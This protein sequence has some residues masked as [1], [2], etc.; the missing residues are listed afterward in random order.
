MKKKFLVNLYDR[1]SKERIAQL[2]VTAVNM[3][4]A[5]RIAVE[6]QESRKSK[7]RR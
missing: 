5:F 3:D 1:Y 4:E 2:I 7:K 6:W